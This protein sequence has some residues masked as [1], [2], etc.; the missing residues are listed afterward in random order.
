MNATNNAFSVL[1]LG[2]FSDKSSKSYS[3]ELVDSLM[4][5]GFLSPILL[6]YAFLC[7][8]LYSSFILG[9]SI[10][11][12]ILMLTAANLLLFDKWGLSL[13]LIF[14]TPYYKLLIGAFLC[15]EIDFGYSFFLP[16]LFWI[17]S[18]G[19]LDDNSL[20]L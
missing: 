17:Y 2:D 7:I 8:L 10:E 20:E 6:L 1:K 4:L 9:L 15:G 16:A 3:P 11:D 13:M 19:S 14:T 5:R 18:I 12:L